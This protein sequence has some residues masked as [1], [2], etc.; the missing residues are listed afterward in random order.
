MS[1]KLK[2]SRRVEIVEKHSTTVDTGDLRRAISAMV[3]VVNVAAEALR[4]GGRGE[5]DR[6][7][8]VIEEATA[9]LAALAFAQ[10]PKEV[11]R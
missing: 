10:I 6:G 1:K 3:S 9:G 5:R 7:R 11:R 8:A 2:T 4:V